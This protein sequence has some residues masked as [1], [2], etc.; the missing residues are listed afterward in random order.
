MA[1]SPKTGGESSGA[2]CLWGELSDIHIH[3]ETPTIRLLRK[4]VIAILDRV[5][6]ENKPKV[7]QISPLQE[8]EAKCIPKWIPPSL[9][10]DKPLALYRN[11]EDLEKML[12][13]QEREDDPMLAYMKQ[14]KKKSQMSKGGK[15]E[16]PLYKGPDPP[17][18]RFNIRP[19]YRW[20]G[21]D[22]SNGFEMKRFAMLANKAATQTQAYKWSSEDM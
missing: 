11:D 17:P 4:Q 19:G 1:N 16:K 18:N 7:T 5:M 6:Q 21:V 8:N 12:E 14:K 13:D 2:N 20:D 10:R 15:K 22:R 3:R 9:E